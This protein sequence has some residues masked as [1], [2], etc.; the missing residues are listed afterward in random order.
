[1]YS[2]VS[3]KI[4]L[5]TDSPQGKLHINTGSRNFV[6]D[7][8]KLADISNTVFLSQN[9]PGS[10]NRDYNGILFRNADLSNITGSSNYFIGS[11]TATAG[12][13]SGGTNI[14]IGDFAGLQLRTGS[15]NINIGWGAGTDNQSGLANINIGVEAGNWNLG[16]DN[17]NIGRGAGYRATNV[18]GN[19]AIGHRALGDRNHTTFGSYNTSIGWMSGFYNEGSYNVFLGCNAGYNE[20]GSNKLY[21]DNSDT[22]AALIGGDFSANEI[23]LNGKVG[24]GIGS[25]TPQEA[26]EVSGKVRT[27]TGFNVSGTDGLTTTY[28]VVTDVNGTAGQKRTSTIT[29]TG[30]IIT[31]IVDNGWSSW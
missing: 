5:G 29:V 26:L 23:Y 25:T 17:V 16:W 30:G 27:N 11:N 19:V 28:T 4:G 22:T 3:G 31:S 20:K 24:V 13:V 2:S 15:Q 8:N 10:N 21:I 1:M 12:T 14:C 7:A 9:C 6:F 18:N